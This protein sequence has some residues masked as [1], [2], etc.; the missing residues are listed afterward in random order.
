MEANFAEKS[1]QIEG[2]NFATAF[3]ILYGAKT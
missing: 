1:R 2:M 3:P